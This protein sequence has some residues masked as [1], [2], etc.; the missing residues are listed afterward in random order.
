MHLNVHYF[1]H[2]NN[3]DILKVFFFFFHKMIYK[4]I[5]FQST[6]FMYVC[7]IFPHL[8]KI[9]QINKNNMNVVL[10]LFVIIKRIK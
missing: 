9:Y 4:Y 5:Y 6:Q 2:L 8:L 1:I 7:M 10:Y 3:N